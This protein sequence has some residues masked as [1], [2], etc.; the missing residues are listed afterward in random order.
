MTNLKVFAVVLVTIAVYTLLANA[1]P[2]VQ[3]EVP[4]E[5]SFGA[6][7]TAEELVSAGETLYQGAGGCT[8]CHGLGTRAPNLLTD[9]GGTGTIGT[10]CARRVSGQDCKT[11]LHESMIEPGKFVVAGYQP[12]MPDLRRT[13]SG[14]QIWALVAYLESLGGEVTVTAE[15]VAAA[16]AASGAAGG[17]AAGGA[18]AGGALAGGSTDPRELIQAGTCL[19]CHKLGAEGGPIGPPF[20]G[21]GGRIDADRIRSGILMPNADTADG[22]AAMAGTM[23]ATFGEQFNAAQLEALVQFLAGL[24]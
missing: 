20:D 23:P 4:A 6:G 8:A 13:L 9:E 18:A 7:V 14:A 16:S 21:M 22:F 24:R 17:A 19:A 11:Y 15:D 3:S 2:Q 5:I 1:I 10:R 12:I